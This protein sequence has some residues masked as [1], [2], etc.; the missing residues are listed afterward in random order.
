MNKDGEAKYD[1][2][3]R[4]HLNLASVVLPFSHGVLRSQ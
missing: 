3:M 1:D 2:S 4:A